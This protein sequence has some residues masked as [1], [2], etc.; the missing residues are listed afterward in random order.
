[1]ATFTVHQTRE[2]LHETHTDDFFRLS[3]NADRYNAEDFQ[4][5]NPVARVEAVDMEHVFHLMNAWNDLDRVRR[6]AP[7]HSLSVGDIIET[8]TGEHEYYI[9]DRFG[10]KKIE[11]C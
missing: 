7:L 6:Y 8:H 4:F 9:V 1:M 11:V 10:F 3:F 5:F 2:D